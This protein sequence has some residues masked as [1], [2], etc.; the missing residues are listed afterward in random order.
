MVSFSHKRD[1]LRDKEKT[2]SAGQCDV[3]SA[4]KSVQLWCAKLWCLCGTYLYLEHPSASD[5][6]NFSRFQVI[7]E[8]HIPTIWHCQPIEAPPSERDPWGVSHSNCHKGVRRIS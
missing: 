5:V 1:L 4:Q 7:A 3:I 8:R 2:S 6:L